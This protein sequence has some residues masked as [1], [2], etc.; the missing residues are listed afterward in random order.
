MNNRGKIDQKKKEG[1][2]GQ[3]LRYVWDNNTSNIQVTG[4]SK[5]Q[6]G[7]LAGLIN[8]TRKNG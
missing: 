7:N 8:V 1:G 5:G 3:S 2:G 6:R 4:V